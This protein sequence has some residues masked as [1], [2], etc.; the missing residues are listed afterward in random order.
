MMPHVSFRVSLYIY[1][2][3]R[4]IRLIQTYDNHPTR[5]EWGD[6]LFLQI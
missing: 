5:G 2:Y 4:K 3:I 1:I 6:D